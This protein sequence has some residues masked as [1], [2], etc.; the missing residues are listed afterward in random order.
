MYWNSRDFSM[1][2]GKHRNV[3]I[4]ELQRT[5]LRMY[6]CSII[7]TEILD[8][9][10]RE[11]VNLA[12]DNNIDIHESGAKSVANIDIDDDTAF[13]YSIVFLNLSDY[14][15]SNHHWLFCIMTARR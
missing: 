8:V 3:E 7:I 1:L 6:V 13:E 10:H 15:M 5:L 11:R 2:V 9:R 14:L 12:E 4:F